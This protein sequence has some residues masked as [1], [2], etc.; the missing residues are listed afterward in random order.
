M[1]FRKICRRMIAVAGILAVTVLPQAVSAA[2]CTQMQYSCGT[3]QTVY[4]MHW[5]GWHC[6]PAGDEVVGEDGTGDG[7]ETDDNNSDYGQQVIDLVNQQRSARGMAE[8]SGDPELTRLAQLKAE[9]MAENGYF[10][11]Q[12]PTYGSAFDMMQA[13]GISYR[14]AGENIAR[15]QSTPEAVMNSWMNSAGHRENILSTSYTSIG[16]GCAADSSG[17]LCWVQLFKG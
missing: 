13:A 11:H 8:L 3:D 7:N 2:E 5:S 14:S 6:G 1:N 15:G 9:D 12:S 16:I 10:S 17:R 4:F